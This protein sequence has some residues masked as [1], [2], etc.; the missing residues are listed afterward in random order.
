MNRTTIIW[1]LASGLAIFAA[2]PAWSQEKDHAEL[3][4]TLPAAKVSLQQGMTA[5]MREGKPISAKFEMDEGKLQLS[6]YTAK[7]DAFSEVIVDHH[8]GKVSKAEA[9]TSGEN[10]T[11]AKT[12]SEAMSKATQSLEAAV[13]KVMKSNSGFKAVSAYPALKDG[14]PIADVTLVKGKQWKAVSAKLD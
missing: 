7:G 11:A 9:I 2:M 10:L 13:A 12:Q 3:S 4:K 1:G 6:V 8:T 14:H 5:S